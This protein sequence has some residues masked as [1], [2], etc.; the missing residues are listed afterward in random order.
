MWSVLPLQSKGMNLFLL[1][2]IVRRVLVP[3]ENEMVV[4]TQESLCLPRKICRRVRQELNGLLSKGDL[5]NR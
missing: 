3:C 2:R 5:Q 4:S 1:E